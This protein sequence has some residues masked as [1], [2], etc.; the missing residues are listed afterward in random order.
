MVRLGVDRA[1]ARAQLQEYLEDDF[2]P[3]VLGGGIPWFQNWKAES[4]EV[5]FG[6]ISSAARLSRSDSAASRRHS[7]LCSYDV[8]PQDVPKF[9]NDSSMERRHSVITHSVGLK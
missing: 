3:D 5:Q 8:Q 4:D 6:S 9:I 2:I 7:D 1:T